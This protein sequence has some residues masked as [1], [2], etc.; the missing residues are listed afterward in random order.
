MKQLNTIFAAGALALGLSS[1]PMLAG[2]GAEGYF[3][4]YNDT[5]GNVLIGFY[6]NDGSGWSANWIEGVEIL[7]GA[8]GQATFNAETGA[9]EQ[10]FQAGWKG[11]DGAEVFDEPISIDICDAS[12]VYLGDNEI[13]FD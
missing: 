9:C 2:T 7:P 6:T 5:A 8:N 12:N 13:S 3:Q 1:A 10:V 11:T 4:I